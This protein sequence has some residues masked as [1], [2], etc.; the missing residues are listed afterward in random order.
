M[1]V[2]I[3]LKAVGIQLI[4]AAIVVFSFTIAE[5]IQKKKEQEK[6]EEAKH[7]E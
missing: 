6:Q 5:R 3:A 1:F 7:A 4:Y 2:D